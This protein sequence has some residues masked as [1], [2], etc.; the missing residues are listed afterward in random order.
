MDPAQL[1]PRRYVF[2]GH[3]TGVAAHIRRPVTK[4]L[5]VQ[6]CSALPVTGGFHESNLGPGQLEKWVSYESVATSAHGDY[7]SA[8]DG[9][10]TT[11]GQ[12]AF[13]AAPTKTHVT[14]SVKGLVILGRVHIGHAAIG[15]ISHSP[16]GAEQ[17]SILL[18]GNVLDD[19]RIDNSRLKITLDEQFYRECDTRHKLATRHAAGLPAGHAC[20]FLPASTTETQLTSFPPNNGTVKCTIV[21]EITWDGAPHPTA[22]IHGHVVRV[23]NFGKIYFGEMFVSDHSRRLTMVRFQLGSDDGGEVTAGD[24]ESS[25]IPY[26]PN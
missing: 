24:G 26:P 12:V 14:A 10:K 9:V 3:S 8:D 1:H 18:E 21:K 22:E 2:R 20:M 4:L 19:V 11:L 16:V 5:P 17:P 23:P 13:D 6:G 7:V 25:G 15:L